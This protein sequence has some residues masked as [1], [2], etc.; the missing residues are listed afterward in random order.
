MLVLVSSGVAVAAP[1]HKP[2]PAPSAASPTPSR[3]PSARDFIGEVFSNS[4]AV[5]TGI[6]SSVFWSERGAAK[7]VVARVFK[8]GSRSRYEFRAAGNTPAHVVIETESSVYVVG[9]EGRDVTVARRDYSPEMEGVRIDL[10]LENYFWRYESSTTG[11]SARKVIAAY[12]K[13]TGRL[14]QRFWVLPRRKVIV[15]SEHYGSHGQLR[16][17][18]SVAPEFVTSLPKSLF[19]PPKGPTTVVREI[20]LPERVSLADVEQ[21][22]GFHPVP[23]PQKALPRGYQLVDT[24]LEQTNEGKAVSLVYS[25]GLESMTLLETPLPQGPRRQ[26]ST[27]RRVKILDRTAQVVSSPEA[28][29]VHWRDRERLYTLIGALAESDLVMYSQEL[30]RSEAPSTKPAHSPQPLKPPPA[31]RRSLGEMLSRGWARF[32]GWFAP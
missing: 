4:Q 25:D 30:I 27:A 8:E 13:E 32:K 2:T 14:V 24:F 17:S 12:N 7:A 23:L 9:P 20:E 31:A 10:A 19:V 16:A 5:Y 28:N 1:A 18:W 26:V 21:R 6:R 29:L 15:R 3:Q 11:R 22:A